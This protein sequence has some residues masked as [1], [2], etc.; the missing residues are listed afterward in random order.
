M[1]PLPVSTRTLLF[2]GVVLCAGAV[3]WQVN[4][5]RL[6]GKHA[7]ELKAM[8]AAG[9]KATERR[10]AQLASLREQSREDSERIA[11]LSRGVRVR[12]ITDRPGVPSPG[13]DADPPGDD[14][15][16]GED[17]IDATNVLRQCLRSFGEINRALRVT[18]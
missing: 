3:G 9:V 1:W 10:D 13:P 2:A 7:S 18:E 4:G 15:A 14:R 8:Y 5:W 17:V 6:N 16:S 11:D 12:C